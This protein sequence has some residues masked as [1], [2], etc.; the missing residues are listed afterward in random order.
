MAL[1]CYIR[2]GATDRIRCLKTTHCKPLITGLRQYSCST[3][4]EKALFSCNLVKTVT[5]I[6]CTDVTSLT[7]AFNVQNTMA[8]LAAAS[9]APPPVIPG[10]RAAFVFELSPTERSAI[11][12]EGK[13]LVRA[14]Q[15][16]F[17]IVIS[18]SCLVNAPTRLHL[19]PHQLCS[20]SRTGFARN[21]ALQLHL[22]TVSK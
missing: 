22:T 16:H 12:Q 2:N 10:H 3:S 15:Q 18:S 9:E 17:F 14:A 6:T 7:I 4:A 8:R 1:L 13:R 19:S 20:A 21:G 5:C 11:K